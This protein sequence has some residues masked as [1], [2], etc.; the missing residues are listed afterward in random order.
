MMLEY[1][2]IHLQKEWLL[3]LGHA[4][5]CHQQ[6]GHQN[7]L[8]VKDHPSPQQMLEA[9]HENAHYLANAVIH[10]RVLTC[11]LNIV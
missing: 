11:F 8:M 7:V 9:L 2:P 4:C 5:H 1:I 3:I 10:I 6:L